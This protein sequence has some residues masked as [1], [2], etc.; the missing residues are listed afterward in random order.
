MTAY[1]KGNALVGKCYLG[2]YRVSFW[3][4]V[5]RGFTSLSSEN[6][7]IVLRTTRFIS[8][9]SAALVSESPAVAIKRLLGGI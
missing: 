4:W 8:A 5:G 9:L 3:G 7:K 6:N 1:V 2:A